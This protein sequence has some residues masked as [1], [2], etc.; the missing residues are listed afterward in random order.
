MREL[1]VAVRR[2]AAA[3]VHVRID[4]GP[5][6]LRAFKPRIEI[7]AK[8]ARHLKVRPLPRCDDDA[9]EHAGAAPDDVDVTVGQR[10]E[11]AGINGQSAG[12]S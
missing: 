1:P 11:R 4:L 9:V 2:D 12:R 3:G 5:K 7:E 10:I 6:R 8:L